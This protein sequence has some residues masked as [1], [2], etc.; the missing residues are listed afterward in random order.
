MDII[1]VARTEDTRV[2]GAD[3]RAHQYPTKEQL[4]SAL[5]PATRK[6]VT[7]GPSS[8]A[9]ERVSLKAS[10]ATL[11]E[12][13]DGAVSLCFRPVSTRRHLE[14]DIRH[15]LTHAMPGRSA[16]QNLLMEPFLT[17]FSANCQRPRSTGSSPPSKS[18]VVVFIPTA[19]V[20][21]P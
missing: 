9:L 15:R 2:Q 1:A 16:K 19:S 20:L 21:L 11:T 4:L 6:G 5:D 13:G 8:P 12:K 17:A 14:G 18:T 7:Y 10:E 3:T